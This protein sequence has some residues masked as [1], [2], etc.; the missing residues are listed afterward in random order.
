MKLKDLKLGTKQMLGF[1]II[2]I[3]MAGSHVYSTRKMAAI[4]A[5]LDEVTNNWLPRAVALSDINLGVSNLY[6]LQLQQAFTTSAEQAQEQNFAMI[7]LLTEIDGNVDIYDSLKTDS[8]RRNLYS[9]EERELYIKFEEQWELY[10]DISIDFFRKHQADHYKKA[11]QLL[12]SEAQQVF[13]EISS[14]LVEL[15]NVN[16]NDSFDAAKRVEVTYNS[17]HKIM[18]ILYVVT[19]LLSVIIA[20]GLVRFITIPVQELELAARKVANGNLDVRL[21][22]STKDEIGNLAHSFNQMTTSLREGKDKTE[23]QA[24]KLRAQNE[25]LERAMLQLKNTQEQLLMKEKMAALG[26]LVAGVAHEI[27]N[28]IGA[29]NSSIDVSDRCIDT[30]ESVIE[31]SESLKEMKNN[32]E[33]KKSLKILKENTKVNLIAG[34]RIATIVKSLKNFARLDEAEYKKVDIHEGID[35]SLTLLGY[36]FLNRIFVSKEYGKIPEFACYPSQLNQVFINILKNASQAIDNSGTISIKTFKK[37]NHIYVQISDTGKGIP[38]N[39]VDKIFNFGFTAGG[40]RIKLT[41]GLSTTYNIVQKHGGEIK[42]ESVP[43]KGTTFSV[44]LPIRKR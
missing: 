30:I 32:L 39:K 41:S 34:E 37:N 13:I 24:A 33:L 17:T 42:V 28:P 15:V 2:L 6:L 8:E 25:D 23:R 19:I 27:N 1:S 22:I 9:D 11:V 38:R 5:E 7:N 29:V 44:I 20:L 31:K 3:I 18:I 36:E 10:K 4:K 43:G 12:T 14:V 21:D 40:E 35:S 16:K 26:D